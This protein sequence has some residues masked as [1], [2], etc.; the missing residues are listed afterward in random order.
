M[1]EIN[2]LKSELAESRRHADNHRRSRD[3]H[4]EQAAK[5][6]KEIDLLTEAVSWWHNEHDQLDA[7]I[8]ECQ[9]HHRAWMAFSIV[10]A[11]YAIGMT[12]LF[13]WCIRS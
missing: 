11:S 6:R 3:Y 8:T 13:A 4:K 10:M 5:L 2:K 12:V 1:E 9:R 7:E